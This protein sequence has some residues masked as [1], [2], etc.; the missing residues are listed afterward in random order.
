MKEGEV[1]EWS[2]EKLIQEYQHRA[3][4]AHKTIDDA[5][6]GDRWVRWCRSLLLR[7]LGCEMVSI[8]G[9]IQRRVHWKE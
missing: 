1:R 6:I 5:V 9:E 8:A 3:K 2:D 4:K 7:D